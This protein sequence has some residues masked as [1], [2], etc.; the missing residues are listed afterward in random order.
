MYWQCEKFA[1]VKCHARIHTEGDLILKHDADATSI[2]ATKVVMDA[3]EKTLMSQ[4]SGHQIVAQATVGVSTAVAAKLPQPSSWMR[5]LRRARHTA[6]VP[7][8]YQIRS[9]ELSCKFHEKFTF[10]MMV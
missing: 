9:L 8:R 10:S 5:S 1:I 7:K 2:D 4:D 3:K 6:D